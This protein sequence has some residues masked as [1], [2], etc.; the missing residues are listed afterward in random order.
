MKTLFLSTIFLLTF[1]LTFGQEDTVGET[2]TTTMTNYTWQGACFDNKGKPLNPS[3]PSNQVYNVKK[4]QSKTQIEINIKSVKLGSQTVS[5]DINYKDKVESDT[6]IINLNDTIGIKVVIGKAT[7]NGIKKYL[8]KFLV[9]K[10]DKGSNCWR[11]MTS[12]NYFY[13]VYAQT[14]SVN[15]Y[16]IGFPNTKDYFQILEGWIKYD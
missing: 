15:L 5:I 8:Y 9:Y 2:T 12:A 6:K 11:P 7:E 1:Q 3:D 10:K 16:A 14:M 13:D 4:F